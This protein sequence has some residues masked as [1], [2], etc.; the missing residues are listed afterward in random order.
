MIETDTAKNGPSLKGSPHTKTYKASPSP[1]EFLPSTSINGSIME[2]H[3][4]L[5][6][7]A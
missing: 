6:C 3:G 1:Q 4:T 2:S 7:I 5:V